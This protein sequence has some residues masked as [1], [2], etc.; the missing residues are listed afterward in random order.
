M[1]ALAALLG[2]LAAFSVTALTAKKFIPKFRNKGITHTSLR[3]RGEAFVP[4]ETAAAFGGIPLGLG[5]AAGGLVGTVILLL[6]G[7][8]LSLSVTLARL[9]G[10]ILLALLLAAAGLLDDFRDIRGLSALHPLVR[11]A[12]QAGIAACYLLALFLCGDRS[13][14]LVLPLVGQGDAGALY[15]ILC[16][17]LLIGAASGGSVQSETG[18]IAATSAMLTG[19]SLAV[20]GGILGSG[21]MSVLGFSLAGCALGV[22]LYSFPPPKLLCGKSGGML[23]GGAAAAAAM[24][25]GIPALLIPAALPLIFEGIFALVKLC[26]FAFAGKR[27]SAESFAGWLCELGFSYRGA[28]LISLCISLAGFALTVFSA[29]NL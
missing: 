24:S 11:F 16:L 9:L 10:G 7:E 27:L 1:T 4:G 13:T 23:F 12:L 20:V 15:Y 26:V 5:F 29:M 17:L 21:P 22:L 6:T 19:F 25:A 14:I 18:D 3:Q 2:A 28:S 8:T